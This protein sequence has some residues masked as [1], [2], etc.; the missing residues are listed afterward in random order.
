MAGPAPPSPHCWQWAADLDLAV[1]HGW[2][3]LLL[4]R[5]VPRW[6]C[7]HYSQALHP[8]MQR[9]V[10]SSSFFFG[11]LLGSAPHEGHSQV[12][13]PLLKRIF[14]E[15]SFWRI[16]MPRWLQ[17]QPNAVPRRWRHCQT[18][19][20]ASAALPA[21]ATQ[22]NCSAGH[23]GAGA[24]ECV[25]MHALRTLH[26]PNEPS[27]ALVAGLLCTAG[28]RGLG[29]CPP[30]GPAE[31]PAC[32]CGEHL[33]LAHGEPAGALSEGGQGRLLGVAAV[34]STTW[35][36]VPPRSCRRSSHPSCPSSSLA[37]ASLAT[38][39][40]GQ[41]ATRWRPLIPPWAI[42]GCCTTLL[43]CFQSF[44]G[45]TGPIADVEEGFQ[46]CSFPSLQLLLT[47]VSSLAQAPEKGTQARL[48]T[49][50]KM[51]VAGC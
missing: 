33:A 47:P 43:P 2:K 38:S 21:L 14:L 25:H 12:L 46:C 50:L 37:V 44:F 40:G 42:L 11:L 51:S 20:Q 39:S 6:A 24:R 10:T 19:Q 4:L 26:T 36:V 30:Q 31:Q 29:C 41:Q 48:T 1:V 32:S 8:V 17:R 3:A 34:L 13:Q 18:G 16:M 27:P 15:R 9:T 7:R 28:E 49:Q 35:R 45:F 23:F 5:H 22:A